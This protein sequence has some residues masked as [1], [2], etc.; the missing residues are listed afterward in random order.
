MIS[1]MLRQQLH[2]NLDEQLRLIEQ[3]A[4]EAACNIGALK[5]IDAAKRL[6]YKS[7]DSIH[8]LV[9]EGKLTKV[10]GLITIQSISDFLGTTPRARRRAVKAAGK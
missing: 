2:E 3:A 9:A 5:P 8:K 4:Q 1:P 6:G 7:A 10:N